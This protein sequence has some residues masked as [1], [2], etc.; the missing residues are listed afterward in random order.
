MS[1]KLNVGVSVL[2]TECQ[3]CGC[4]IYTSPIFIYVARISDAMHGGKM[5]IQAPNT[6]YLHRS[7]HI[8]SVWKDGAS[9]QRE[10][11]YICNELFS[12]GFLEPPFYKKLVPPHSLYCQNK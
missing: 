6:V 3:I 10:A 9:V 2:F 8:G 7:M 1:H 11:S 12:L 5:A 4:I